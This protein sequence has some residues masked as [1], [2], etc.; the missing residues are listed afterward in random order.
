M[1][2]IVILGAGVMGSAMALPAIAAG[3][4]VAVVGTPLDTAI[5]AA[6]RAGEAHPCL[7]RPAVRS[8]ATTRP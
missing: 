8:T 7:C 5:V 2:A 6:L 4:S 1:A 3:S